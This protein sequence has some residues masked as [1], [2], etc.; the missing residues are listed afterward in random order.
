MGYRRRRYGGR[1][2]PRSWDDEYGPQVPDDEYRWRFP[3]TAS[4]YAMSKVY[5]WQMRGKYWDAYYKN[6]GKRPNKYKYNK[7]TRR[8]Y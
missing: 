2:R 7:L 5:D 4:F 8:R 6:T 1:P 3:V